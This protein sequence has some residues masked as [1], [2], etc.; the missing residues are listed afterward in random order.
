MLCWLYHR[1]VWL[2]LVYQCLNQ[3]HMFTCS[4]SCFLAIPSN[5]HWRASC[6]KHAKDWGGG[7][8]HK[9]AISISLSE[10]S[11]TAEVG[12]TVDSILTSSNFSPQQSKTEGRWHNISSLAVNPNLLIDNNLCCC[13]YKGFKAMKSQ[14]TLELI[15]RVLADW[16][17]NCMK[18]KQYFNNWELMPELPWTG[19]YILY[20]LIF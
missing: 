17:L 6:C 7:H 9:A 1:E 11:I 4:A 12:I 5:H 3:N 15:L 19:E 2:P 8:P 16:P 13:I 20:L 18:T 14:I 10:G